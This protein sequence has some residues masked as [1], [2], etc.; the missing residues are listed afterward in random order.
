MPKMGTARVLTFHVTLSDEEYAKLTELAE[1]HDTSKVAV[2]RELITK[3]YAELIQ[4]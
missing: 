3:R 4:C 1:R 2:I